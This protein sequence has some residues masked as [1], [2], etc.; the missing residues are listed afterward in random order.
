MFIIAFFKLFSFSYS[1]EQLRKLPTAEYIYRPQVNTHILEECPTDDRSYSHIEQELENYESKNYYACNIKFRNPIVLNQGLLL[2]YNCN[3]TNIKSSQGVI[4]V[5][6]TSDSVAAQSI[7]IH[8][9]FFYMIQ[10]ESIHIE[11]KSE[12]RQVNI[13]DCS[14]ERCKIKANSPVIYFKVHT[15]TIEKC[16]FLNNAEREA[17]ADIKYVNEENGKV[18]FKDNLFKRDYG[19]NYKSNLISFDSSSVFDFINNQISIMAADV[20]L[21]DWPDDL[22]DITNYKFEGNTM[23][24]LNNGALSNTKGLLN[25]KFPEKNDIECPPSFIE[26]KPVKNLCQSPFENQYTRASQTEQDLIN[27][28]YCIF[29]NIINTKNDKGGAIYIYTGKEMKTYDEP[30]RVYNSNFVYCDAKIGSAIYIESYHETIKYDFRDCY[31]GQ[32][33]FNQNNTVDQNILKGGAIYI[34]TTY[35][36]F[37][38]SRCTFDRNHAGDGGA[39]CFISDTS[40]AEETTNNNNNNI[41]S[42]YFLDCR[43]YYNMG[44]SN[45]GSIFV[46][47]IGREH[48]RPNQLENCIF[49]YSFANQQDGDNLGT[50]PELPETGGAIYYSTSYSTLLSSSNNCDLNIV[51]CD[52]HSCQTTFTGGAITIVITNKDPSRSIEINRC[53]FT[54]NVAAEACFD[55]ACSSGADVY[56]EYDSESPSEFTDGNILRINDCYSEKSN[57]KNYGSSISISILKGEPSKSIEINNCVFKSCRASQTGGCIY[58]NYLTS[59]SSL[60]GT[61][62]HSLY[63]VDCKFTS[64]VTGEKGGAIAINIA[65][66]EPSNPIEIK[67]CIFNSNKATDENVD[68]EYGGAIYYYQ[69]GSSSKALLKSNAAF[70]LGIFGCEFNENQVSY[71]GGAI[72]IV[73]ENAEPSKPIEINT[74]SFNNN[75]ATNDKSACGASLYYE[76]KTSATTQDSNLENMLSLTVINCSFMG[77]VAKDTGDVYIETNTGGTVKRSIEF[78]QCSFKDS[79]PEGIF[80]YTNPA[81]STSI[82]EC[83]FSTSSNI[84]FYA[85]TPSAK[86]DNCTFNDM[87]S[88][89]IKYQA[90]KDTMSNENELRIENCVFNQ[91]SDSIDCLVYFITKLSSPFYFISNSITIENEKTRC[92]GSKDGVLLEVDGWNFDSNIITPG[93]ENFIKTS[94]AVII[95]ASC[96]NGFICALEPPNCVDN[97]RCDLNSTNGSVEKPAVTLSK[98]QFNKLNTELNGGAI[99]IINYD[100]TGYDLTIVECTAQTGGGGGI[101]IY[102]DKE[103]EAAIKLEKLKLSKCSAVYGGA[104]F[105]YTKIEANMIDI[106]NCEFNGNNANENPTADGDIYYGG[107]AVF[108]AAVNGLIRKSKFRNNFGHGVKIMNDFEKITPPKML[109][110]EGPSASVSIVDCVFQASENTKSSIFYVR[111][112]KKETNV[113]VKGCTFEGE[114]KD[115]LHHINGKS[116]VKRNDKMNL[117]IQSCKFSSG[118]ESAI[119]RRS[120]GLL[121]ESLEINGNEFKSI[122]KVDEKKNLKYDMKIVYLV[123]VLACIATISAFFIH[124][125]MKKQEQTENDKSIEL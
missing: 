5:I 79:S 85:D 55:D 116:L 19:N 120:S 50:K 25:G 60:T 20:K 4:T 112:G 103:I 40:N 114:I 92:L 72:S 124:F 57:S 115:G 59:T 16:I 9:C 83:N 95:P 51:N 26:D 88:N 23:Y 102:L 104:I 24:P 46:S 68:N 2:I 67:G 31:F 86:I 18:T 58:Y 118:E 47:L 81:T 70:I 42:L 113:E 34:A 32:N 121:L 66:Q 98:L 6:A 41:Y 94:N 28:I 64:C 14:F 12:S 30:I 45:G 15:G 53:T 105:A 3:F 77:G 54:G 78:S 44:Y 122:E 87:T 100:F 43:F 61:L 63:V 27:I 62:I 35:S 109:S 101:Y 69:K 29:N 56:F 125:T 38:F 11:A 8:S 91:V 90:L 10:K 37:E 39:I 21:F 89:A 111:G 108:M 13:V 17:A 1:N 84:F 73:I 71:F 75:L 123:V 65:N 96:K 76:F 74:C 22:T 97:Q 106:Y 52:F 7:E 99:H 107:S 93:K 82:K 36:T 110:L 117:H 80:L 33:S 119:N 49:Y 48:S